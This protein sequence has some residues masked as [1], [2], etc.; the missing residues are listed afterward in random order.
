MDECDFRKCAGDIAQF[1]GVF[2]RNVQF[3][4]NRANAPVATKTLYKNFLEKNADAV[5]QRDR[6]GAEFG[7]V[8]YGGGV[9]NTVV[10]SQSSAL[11]ALVG[12]AA[13]A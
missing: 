3:L 8:W 11:D 13:V 7:S 12:A 1:K 2:A 10:Q 5:W 4:Y 9:Y 6:S